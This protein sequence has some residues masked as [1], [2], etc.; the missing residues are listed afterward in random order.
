MSTHDDVAVLSLR[1]ELRGD[2]PVV[3][4]V[5]LDESEP[6]PQEIARKKAKRVISSRD[7]VVAFR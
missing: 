4:E 6:T 7:V 1:I 3:R 5:R 2:G